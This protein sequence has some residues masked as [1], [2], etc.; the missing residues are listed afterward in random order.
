MSYEKRPA[1]WDA[2]VSLIRKYA[3]PLGAGTVALLAA[4]ALFLARGGGG[5]L[6]EFPRE[7]KDFMSAE[8]AEARIAELSKRLAESPEDI[9][10]LDESG[11]LKFQLGQQR[12]VEAIAD[13]E[14]ARSHGLADPR[15]F[16]YLGV[17][18]Q[19]VGLYDFAAQEYRRFL[20]NYPADAEV[21]MLLGKLYY[22]AGDYAAAV[23][24]YEALRRDG[25]GD[26][27]LLE[28]LV[29]AL[30]KDKRDYTPAIAE[31][32]SKGAPGAFLADYAE[33]RIRY[34]RKE[35]NGA[36]LYLAR[37]ADAAA[38][39]GNFADLA[40]LYWMAADASN[41]NKDA[42]AAYR[43]SSELARLDPGHAEN[44]ALLA[45]LERARA[46]L[47]QARAEA[48]K[49]EARAREAAAKAAAKTA[50]KK[51]PAPGSASTAK[52]AG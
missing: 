34:E 26:P 35:Y 39:A 12:Y 1:N 13:L 25:A 19:A 7:K 24:E 36:Q 5:P 38:S 14:R 8:R 11:R 23:R 51:A 6:P 21:R 28:N 48:E 16:Y 4:L 18:Y 43:Y 20:N 9:R 32:R 52:K 47:A 10:A 50:P 44:A 41:R 42:E 31:L 46:A 33:G 17:M 3:A 27:V 45:R 49:A 22:A 40:A 29:L 15:S 37:A 30:W 2:P